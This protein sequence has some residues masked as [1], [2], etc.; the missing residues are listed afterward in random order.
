MIRNRKLHA[1]G[2]HHTVSRAQNA[3]HFHFPKGYTC[4]LRKG[5]YLRHGRHGVHG[6]TRVGENE[7]VKL[8]PKRKKAW[9]AMVT[10]G[11]TG[12]RVL[13]RRTD[14]RFIL[15]FSTA[16]STELSN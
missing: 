2:R 13:G 8:V 7:L 4:S 14:I 12:D 9:A 5:I 10:E 6:R 15:I 11:R 16:T 1:S 3:Q